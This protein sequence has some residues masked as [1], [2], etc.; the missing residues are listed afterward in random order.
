[1]LVRGRSTL[2]RLSGASTPGR[3]DGERVVVVVVVRD[4]VEVR[5]PGYVRARTTGSEV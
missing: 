1:M 5:G 3:E 4:E 2:Q